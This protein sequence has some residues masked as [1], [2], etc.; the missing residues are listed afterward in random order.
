[1][2]VSFEDRG[3]DVF[4]TEGIGFNVRPTRHIIGHFEDESLQAIDCTGTDKQKRGNQTLHTRKTQ[5]QTE[6][7]NKT[8]TPGSSCLGATIGVASYGSLGHKPPRLLTVI[9]F[10]SPRSCAKSTTATHVCQAA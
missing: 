2:V 8:S 4:H 10:S 9:V 3:V 1:M 7:A 5:N 6:K